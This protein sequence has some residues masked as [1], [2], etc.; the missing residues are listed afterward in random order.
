MRRRLIDATCHPSYSR[1]N[2]AANALGASQHD[3]TLPSN[4]WEVGVPEACTKYCL[5]EERTVRTRVQPLVVWKSGESACVVCK[6]FDL[7]VAQAFE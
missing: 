3:A 4:C 6:K 5:K 7:M 1:A 2:S